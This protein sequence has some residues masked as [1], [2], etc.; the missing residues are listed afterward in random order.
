MVNLHLDLE[1]RSP[2]DL[3]AVGPRRYA[4]APGAAVLLCAY[5]FDDG[6]VQVWEACKGPMPRELEAA[7]RDPHVLK[8]AH[9]A[10]FERA[11]LED[12]LGIPCPPEQ[13]RCTQALALS[14]ALPA[15]LE[16]CAEALGLPV[17]KDPAGKRLIKLF[18]QPHDAF[19]EPGFTPPEA[20]PED[21]RAFVDYCRRDVEVERAIHMALIDHD[22]PAH[23]WALWALD[24]RINDRG[25]PV[26][27]ALVDAALRVDAGNRE[28]L[29]ARA[30]EIT[31]LANPNSREQLLAWL[32]DQ[33]VEA[34]AL[35]RADVDELI[36]REGLTP[37]ALEMLSIRRQLART[38]VQKF[39]ALARATGDDG[40]VRGCFQFYGARTGRWAGR[41]FQP[42]NIARGA[43][44]T[45][46][47]M[48]TAREAV[49]TGDAEFVGMAYDDDVT[50]VLASLIRPAIRAPEGR[51]LVV[52]DYSSIESVMVAWAAGAGNMLD[53]FR[54]GRD[55]YKDFASRLF[56]VGYEAV[57]KKQRQFAKPAVL[58]AVYMLG[59]R[60]L[61]AYAKNYGVELTDTEADRHIRTFREAYPAIPRF[62]AR[63]ADA[64]FACAA[65]DGATARVGA[66]LFRR[67]GL[68]L[69]IDLPG[70][71]SLAYRR[72][73]IELVEGREAV[74]Y[75]GVDNCA[76][77]WGR[78]TTHPGKLTENI[79]QAIA[80]DVLKAGLTRA[81][82]DPGLAVVGHVHDEIIA[83]AD[84]DDEPALARLIG[85]MT[86]PIGWC[87]DAPIRAAGWEGCFYRKD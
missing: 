30:R 13:W 79:V 59:A 58:G 39:Q 63:L 65:K 22:M 78:L 84:A 15:S 41:I 4:R 73:R 68:W 5:A 46:E 77:K 29:M 72:P 82:A 36:S 35:T 40:R 43:L 6:P 66:F 11:M 81:A 62:W 18:S 33:G 38:S 44:P 70:G 69:F 17:R 76:R 21:W 7:L 23:E 64:A 3:A 54:D 28:R 31:G 57:T 37:E 52:A 8:W 80:R 87:A 34:E 20:A 48:A 10:A 56:G 24:Q 85:H 26:D 75:D 27:R 12:V 16:A 53:V 67:E 71:R 74:C 61:R 49:L 55:I 83:E 50:E 2:A 47:A 14:L 1:T 51:K 86:A 25:L 42:Q 60:G 19:G 32:S 9:N 45:P